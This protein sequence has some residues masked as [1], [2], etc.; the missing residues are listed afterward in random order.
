MTPLRKA[1]AILFL[2]IY[3]FSST[4]LR[5][6]VKFPLLIQHYLEHK[7]LNRN[8]T[9]ASFITMH[10]ESNIVDNDY[11]KDQQL[12]FKSHHDC[13]VITLGLFVP[14]VTCASVTKPVTDLND[15]HIISNDEFINSVF[16]SSVW[17]PPKA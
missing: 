3:L 6:L 9:F 1:A 11:A 14:A 15:K 17:Q 4:E 5:Q 8:I 7:A 10:Y 2:G 13:Q 12:P 16:L